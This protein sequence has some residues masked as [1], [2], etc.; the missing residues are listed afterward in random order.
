MTRRTA[1]RET[2]STWAIARIPLDGE[3]GRE[4]LRRRRRRGHEAHLAAALLEGAVGDE[5]VQVH[6]QPEVGAALVILAK[7][8]PLV[9]RLQHRRWVLGSALHG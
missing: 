6:E 1:L 2:R 5:S 9:R 7:L 4:P 8:S 3:H